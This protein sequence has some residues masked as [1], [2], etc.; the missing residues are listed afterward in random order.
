[1]V[2][3]AQNIRKTPK[4][5]VFGGG[6]AWSTLLRTPGISG[7]VSS[8]LCMCNV[9]A[10]AGLHAGAGSAWFWDQNSNWMQAGPRAG[11]G[12]TLYTITHNA[13]TANFLLTLHCDIPLT[14]TS[15]PLTAQ[16]AACGW[17]GWL[18]W[19]CEWYSV[20]ALL[21]CDW[22]KRNLQRAE[23]GSGGLVA[24]GAGRAGWDH[25]TG[26]QCQVRLHTCTAASIHPA[27]AAVITQHFLQSHQPRS[28]NEGRKTNINMNL[29]WFG[30]T[31]KDAWNILLKKTELDFFSF[32]VAWSPQTGLP[33]PPCNSEK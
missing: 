4:Y 1:M 9:H 25:M 24:A 11:G 30:C 10:P 13:L 29:K 8:V 20:A 6:L 19:D 3:Q 14:I 33:P 26:G 32:R 2:K 7:A 5:K 27:P 16:S 21:R 12:V 31:T 18:V 28:S 22:L 15:R 17:D 23:S